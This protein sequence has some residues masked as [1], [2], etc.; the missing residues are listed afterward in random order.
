MLVSF[1]TYDTRRVNV[2]CRR[3]AYENSPLA[4]PYLSAMHI[5]KQAS[6]AAT[7]SQTT[8]NCII[9]SLPACDNSVS[10]HLDPSTFI[11]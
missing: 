4:A 11:S 6:Y 5:L 3:A 7:E 10:I 9:R 8:I 1:L 2:K